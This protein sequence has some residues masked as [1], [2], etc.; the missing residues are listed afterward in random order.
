[1]S[2][3]GKTLEDILAILG[4]YKAELRKKYHIRKLLIFGSYAESRQTPQSDLDLI[5]E[6]DR[7]PTLLE[8]V[9]IEQALSH[10]LGVQ[11]DLLTEESIS[12]FIRPYITT[13]EVSLDE[14]DTTLS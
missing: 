10:L 7:V 3:S 4:R 9:H 1:M 8:L 12:P 14:S 5:A 2:G 13:V 11:V 6:F